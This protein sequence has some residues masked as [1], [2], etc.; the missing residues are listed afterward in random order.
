MPKMNDL[1]KFFALL[2]FAAAAAGC[3]TPAEPQCSPAPPEPSRIYLSKR[4]DGRQLR[5]SVGD[6]LTVELKSNP[7]TG[8]RWMVPE[9]GAKDV[10]KLNSDEFFAPGT[11]LCGAPGRQKL[12]FTAAS[13]GETELRIVYIRPWKKDAPPAQ[14]FTV[15]VVVAEG[16]CASK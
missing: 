15:K 8:F 13:P 9:E 2:L 1:A 11:D 4:D 5:L 12:S 16:S 7:T 6:T 3:G 14:K 10:L